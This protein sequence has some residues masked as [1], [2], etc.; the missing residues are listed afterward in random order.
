LYFQFDRRR[1]ERIEIPD[2]QTYF[3]FEHMAEPENMFEGPE[4]LID[5]SKGGI[6]FETAKTIA[7]DDIL[8]VKLAIPDEESLILKGIVRWTGRVPRSRKIRIG[9]RFTLFGREEKYN[10]PAALERL[11]NLQ[12]RFRRS[13]G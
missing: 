10:S 4:K 8:W 3:K 11:E 12:E 6:S 5:L 7:P 1:Q 9:V 13:G 2:A